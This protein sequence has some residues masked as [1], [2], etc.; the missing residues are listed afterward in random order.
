MA[1]CLKWGQSSA[2]MWNLY[3]LTN[4]FSSSESV[5][6]QAPRQCPVAAKLQL[7]SPTACL[8]SKVHHMNTVYLTTVSV[9]AYLKNE[10]NNKLSLMVM[11]KIKWDNSNLT[12]W[13]VSARSWQR[14]QLWYRYAHIRVLYKYIHIIYIYIYIMHKFISLLSL[15]YQQQEEL[16][17]Y[18]STIDNK[19]ILI[20]TVITNT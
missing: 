12:Q 20:I 16:T 18:N 9:F 3:R 7:W 1:I 10:A 4:V 17:V 11:M 19:R 2:L 15:F 13:L 6:S 8:K 14:L 5:I